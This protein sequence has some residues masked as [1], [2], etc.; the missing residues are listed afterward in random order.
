MGKWWITLAEAL[1]KILAN[2]WLAEQDQKKRSNSPGVEIESKKP[3][4]PEKKSTAILHEKKE[5]K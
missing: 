4:V 3:V 2:R 5:E 1:A